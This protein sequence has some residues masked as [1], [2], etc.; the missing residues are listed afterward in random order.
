MKTIKQHIF[1]RLIISKT[2]PGD[3]LSYDNLLYILK[4]FSPNGLIDVYFE[5]LYKEPQYIT[6]KDENYELESIGWNK[7]KNCVELCTYQAE[8][9]TTMTFWCIENDEDIIRYLGGDYKNEQLALEYVKLIIDY[10]KLR[11]KMKK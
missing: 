2:K 8:G 9:A 1:E 6:I 11:I 10:A 4:E 3:D 7:D 5:R